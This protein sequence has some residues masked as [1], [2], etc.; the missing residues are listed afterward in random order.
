MRGATLGQLRSMLRAEVADAMDAGASSANNRLYDAVLANKQ[1]WLAGDYAW[2]WRKREWDVALA[3]GVRRY[4]WP[5]ECSLE[6]PVLLQQ[7]WSNR[8]TEPIPH[9]IDARLFNGLDPELDQRCDPISRWDWY[10]PAD[11][12]P[13]V[14]QL[15][16]WPLPSTAG[17]LRI[18]GQKDLAPLTGDDNTA[19]LDDL[20]IV[21]FAAAE[22]LT[23]RKQANAQAK[24]AQAS[25]RLNKLRAQYDRGP[26]VWNMR[27]SG[28]DKIWRRF[29]R[30]PR[31]T[32]GVTV[33]QES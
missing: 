31:S 2:P 7:K 9:G 14:M 32:V 27:A 15:E 5:E 13:H 16:V 18:T 6:Y 12:A 24:L 29:Q 8:W 10:T 25:A 3:P 30:G 28:A 17:T 4:T 33:I 23:Q 20:L 22:I 11:A 19:E 21:L 1:Q 26:G